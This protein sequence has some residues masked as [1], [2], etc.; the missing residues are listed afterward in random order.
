M[1]R[2]AILVLVLCCRLVSSGVVLSTFRQEALDEH[3]AKRTLHCVPSL[4]LNATLNDIAQNYS[5]YLAANRLFAHSG[6]S[7]LG[8]NLWMMSSSVAITSVTGT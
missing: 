5:E 7:G 6:A 1:I 8:E 2:S 3:N 4:M